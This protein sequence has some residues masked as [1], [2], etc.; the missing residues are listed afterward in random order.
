MNGGQDKDA[1]NDVK[2]GVGKRQLT[3]FVRNITDK[4]VAPQRLIV[5]MF[6]FVIFTGQ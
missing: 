3:S 4:C 6:L 1:D 5:T 2:S